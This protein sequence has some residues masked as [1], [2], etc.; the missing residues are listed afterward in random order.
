MPL[1]FSPQGSEFFTA[2]QHGNQIVLPMLRYAAVRCYITPQDLE[3]TNR[4]TPLLNLQVGNNRNASADPKR[5]LI[6][7]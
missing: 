5:V 6:F 2:I 7:F 3:E 1:V 4:E